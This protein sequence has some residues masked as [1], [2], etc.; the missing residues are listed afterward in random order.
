MGVGKSGW[1]RYVPWCVSRVVEVWGVDRWAWMALLG[2]I[3]GSCG[4]LDGLFRWEGWG[5]GCESAQELPIAECT[6]PHPIHFDDVLV[7]LFD[8]NHNSS[9][10][11]FVGVVARLVLNEDVVPYAEG[12][13]PPGVF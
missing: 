2:R 3:L 10:V 13:E 1:P 8:L 6:S 4:E 12:R 5:V 7:V 9:L 11:P